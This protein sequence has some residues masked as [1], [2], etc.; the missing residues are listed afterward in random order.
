MGDADPQKERDDRKGE[1]IILRKKEFIAGGKVF[2]L[3]KT[4]FIARGV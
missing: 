3:R 1:V 4:E 2:V